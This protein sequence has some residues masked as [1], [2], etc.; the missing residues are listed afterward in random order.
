MTSDPCLACG[1]LRTRDALPPLAP[2]SDLSLFADADCA[3][4]QV[5]ISCVSF[6]PPYLSFS[7][8]LFCF[9][10][11]GSCVSLSA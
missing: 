4:Y 11:V 1:T 3:V 8:V 10:F 7:G 5:S 6:C 9:S 2:A